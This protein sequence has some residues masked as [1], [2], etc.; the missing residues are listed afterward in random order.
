MEECV[1]ATE[2]CPYSNIGC[3][4]QGSKVNLANHLEKMLADHLHLACEV[5]DD[6]KIELERQ[7]DRLRLQDQA[8]VQL[9]D[10]VVKIKQLFDQQC[11]T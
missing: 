1:E 9:N 4:F 8:I 11:S 6:Q 3:S 2:I 7:A 5:V 10:T